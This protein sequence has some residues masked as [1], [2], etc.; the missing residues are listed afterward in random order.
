L[1]VDMRLRALFTGVIPT[2]AFGLDL[3]ASEM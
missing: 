2:P 1:A 3:P